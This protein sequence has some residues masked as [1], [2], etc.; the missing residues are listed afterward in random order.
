MTQGRLSLLFAVVILA[1]L[2]AQRPETNYDE[3]KVP[4]Y[5]LPD[6]LKCR[7]G[8]EA[9]DADAWWAKR[10]PE[11]VGLFE[12]NM[13]GRAPGKPE[14]LSFEVTSTGEVFRGKG[15]DKIDRLRQ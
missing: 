13:Y 6:V 8:S 11:I 2:P 3:S 7:D 4:A 5:E 14:Q 15:V 9:K 1:P 10:R 12:Q